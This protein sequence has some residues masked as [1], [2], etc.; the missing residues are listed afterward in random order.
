MSR[1]NRTSEPKRFAFGWEQTSAKRGKIV[2]PLRPPARA[3]D[4][5]P[6]ET[7]W[8]WLKGRVTDALAGEKPTTER[9]K[10]VIATQFNEIPQESIDALILGWPA[11]LRYVATHGGA[12][13]PVGY[14]RT[15]ARRK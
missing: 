6:I 7:L 11:R 12:L 1:R 4:P 14:R 3:A 9:L 13:I 10:A 8:A 15:D 2:K 5:V